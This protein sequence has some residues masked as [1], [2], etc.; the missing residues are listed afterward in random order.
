MKSAKQAG[1]E[2]IP[3]ALTPGAPDSQPRNFNPGV[4]D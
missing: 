1:R 3:G 4:D 2:A